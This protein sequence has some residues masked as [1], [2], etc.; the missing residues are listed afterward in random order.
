MTH[1]HWD[2]MTYIV[3]KMHEEGLGGGPASHTP[4]HKSTAVAAPFQV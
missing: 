2:T 3:W 4:A 1:Y